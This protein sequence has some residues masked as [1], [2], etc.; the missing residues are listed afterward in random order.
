MKIIIFDNDLLPKP[1]L[2]PLSFFF[3]FGATTAG[4]GAKPLN[5]LKIFLNTTL[6]R[7]SLSRSSLSRSTLSRS[8]LSRSSL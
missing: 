3:F 2:F 4:R 1:N 5:R 8:S 6:S 7:S